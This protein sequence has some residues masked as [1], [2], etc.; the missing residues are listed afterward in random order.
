L[1]AICNQV[2]CFTVRF[3]EAGAHY[4]F[5]HTVDS[6]GLYRICTSINKDVRYQKWVLWNTTFIS[7]LHFVFCLKFLSFLVFIAC[8]PFLSFW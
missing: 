6:L 1:L 2:N 4:T 8:V 3:G 5:N 7:S